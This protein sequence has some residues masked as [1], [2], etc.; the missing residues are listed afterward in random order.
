MNSRN[1]IETLLRQ[2]PLRKPSLDLDVRVMARR[3][4]PTRAWFIGAAG[5]A[6]AAAAVVMLI[7]GL[8]QNATHV[9]PGTTLVGGGNPVSL[10]GPTAPVEPVRL[11]Q[12]WSELSYEGLVLPDPQTPLQTF[13]HRTVDRVQFFDPLRNIRMETT[14]PREEVIFVKASMQ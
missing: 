9:T 6:L 10:P 12:N 2:M 13:R 1:D 11:E 5:G 8:P 7:V 4:H 3:P 14:V